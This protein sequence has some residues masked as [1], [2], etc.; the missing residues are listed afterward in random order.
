ME[1][2]EKVKSLPLC[3]GIYLMKDSLD[4]IIYVGKSKSLK[5]RVQSYFQSSSA[6]TPKVKKLVKNLKDFDYILTDT[7][8]EAFML[9]CKYIKELK[10]IYNRLMKNPLSY[11]YV[12][13]HTDKIFP[14]IWITN[15]LNHNNKSLYFGPFTSR[16]TV[17]KAIEGIK[18]FYKIICSNPSKKNTSCLNYSLGKCLGMCLGGSAAEQYNSIINK[19]IGLFDNTDS[20]IIEEIEEKML[21]ASENFDFETAAKYRDIIDTIKILINK[22]KI[23][24]FTE[25]NKNIA[26]IEKL[27][28]YTFKLFLIKRN[29]VLFSEKYNIESV[30]IGQLTRMIES[31]IL[32][33]YQDEVLPP[34]KE[35]TKDEIDE[36]EIIYSYLK[37]SKCRYIIVPEEWLF[38]KNNFCINETLSKLLYEVKTQLS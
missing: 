10:P 25:E 18:E 14:T 11:T 26:V 6:H 29:K 35:V 38:P 36:A 37:S 19:I 5:K 22:E 20:N 8:F 1:L 33:Y 32:T 3:P 28:D 9:E 34:H 16:S 7:E 21:H 30:D 23:I 17:E 24:D 31:N 2:K 12:E 27:N 13:I 15:T 4:N